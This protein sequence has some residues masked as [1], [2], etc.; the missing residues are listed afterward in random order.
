MPAKAGIQG[1]KKLNKVKSWIPAS[2]GMTALFPQSETVS[3]G[4]GNFLRGRKREGKIC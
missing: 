4:E 3:P 1:F 2:A